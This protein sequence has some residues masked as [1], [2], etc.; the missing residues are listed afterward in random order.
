VKTGLHVRGLRVL[1]GSCPVVDGVDLDAA[2]GQVTALIGPNGSGKSTVLKAILGLLPSSGEIGLDGRDLR[3]LAPLERARALAYVPQRS[4]LA[5]ALPV[6]A[7]VAQGRYAHGDLLGGGPADRQA[8]EDA[9]AQTDGRHLRGRRFNA[10][11][12][13]EQQ[14]VLVA[15]A[16]AS[17]ANCILLDEPT[18]AL[19]VGHALS[20]LDLVRRL[21]SDGRAVLAVLH[22]LDEVA[23]CADSCVLLQ[24]GRGVAA[25]APAEVLASGPLGAVFGVAPLPQGALGFRLLEERC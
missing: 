23:R 22:H 20:L 6:E 4:L 19:D 15:R 11:S 25:G 9:L 5:S 3:R 7:V 24:R 14:R 13:G 16:L 8:V 10:L 21:A 1:R 18:G 2:P 12:C 17:G